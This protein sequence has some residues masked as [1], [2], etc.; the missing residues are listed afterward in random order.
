MW[1]APALLF[2]PSALQSFKGSSAPCKFSRVCGTP[3]LYHPRRSALL[4]QGHKSVWYAH[5]SSNLGAQRSHNHSRGPL[6]PSISQGCVVRPRPILGA[7]RSPTFQGVVFPLQG[8]KSVW[9]THHSL[10][11]TKLGAQRSFIHFRGPL[12]PSTS[13]GCVVRPRPSL[14][15]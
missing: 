1:Y 4:L 3:P 6:P 8:I 9:Y 11:S 12:P 5:H 7:Q 15:A 2:E 10:D 14:G 13:Q